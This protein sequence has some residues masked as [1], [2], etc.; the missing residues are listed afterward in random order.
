MTKTQAA[1]VWHNDAV[2]CKDPDFIGIVV[3]IKMGFSAFLVL[4]VKFMTS[5][6]PVGRN[7][8]EPVVVTV[9]LM[10]TAMLEQMDS[11]ELERN[12]KISLANNS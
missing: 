7:G 8:A 10:E 9:E 11:V 6:G 3:G 12:K 2:R 5:D 4:P 1:N